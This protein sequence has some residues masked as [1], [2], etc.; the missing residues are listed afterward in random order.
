VI[1]PHLFR[2]HADEPTTMHQLIFCAIFL[3][4]ALSPL[5]IAT[6]ISRN[7]REESRY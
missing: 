7:I 2:T 6:Q 3:T 5:V 4:I 1:R